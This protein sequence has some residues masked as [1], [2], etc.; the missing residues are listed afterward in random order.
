[1]DEEGVWEEGR[2]GFVVDEALGGLGFVETGGV[3]EEGADRTDAVLGPLASAVGNTSVLDASGKAG[4][5]LCWP[6]SD[7][8]GSIT[9][10]ALPGGQGTARPT[11]DEEEGVWVE[12]GLRFVVDGSPGCQGFTKIGGGRGDG[13]ATPAA[14]FTFG[15]GKA[16]SFAGAVRALVLF[17]RRDGVGA[18]GESDVRSCSDAA[19]QEEEGR[20]DIASGSGVGMLLRPGTGA[21]LEW[22]SPED[23]IGATGARL[24]GIT[25][26]D[27]SAQFAVDTNPSGGGFAK[28]GVASDGRIPLF[29][30]G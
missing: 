24:G 3:F 9:A 23:G 12:G 16:R 7:N 4:R 2:S 1:M 5:A 19:D 15:D 10:P 29:A 22:S 13:M 11:A 18:G 20:L 27:G 30:G 21:L 14:T 17:G 26:G 25:P 6:P 28:T 8:G